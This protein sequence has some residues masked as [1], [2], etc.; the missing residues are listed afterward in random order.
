MPVE[1]VDFAEGSDVHR[2]ELVLVKL[3]DAR[4]VY[5]PACAVESFHE[6]EETLQALAEAEATGVGYDTLAKAVRE[7]R[8]MG[9]K[10]AGTWLSTRTA[11][12]YALAQGRIRP[13]E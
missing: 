12:E 10:S 4:Q 2:E 1:F 8:L 6:P 7:G 13:Q 9:R 3:P 11:V 5:V